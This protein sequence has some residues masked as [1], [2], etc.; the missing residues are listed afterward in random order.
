MT[1][2]QAPVQ[3]GA[4]EEQIQAVVSGSTSDGHHTFDELYDY[5]MLYNA[6]SAN[7]WLEAG[8][9]VVKSWRHSDGEL[10]FGGGWFIVTAT[11]PTGQ[12]S[13]HYRAANW[14]LF[15]VPEVDLPPKYDGHSPADAADRLRRAL[16]VSASADPSDEHHDAEERQAEC[17]CSAYSE[18]RGGGYFELMLEPEPDCPEHGA[19]IAAE[20]EDH[21]ATVTGERDGLAKALCAIEM[22]SKAATLEEV[23]AGIERWTRHRHEADRLIEE[24]YDYGLCL[25]PT[26]GRDIAGETEAEVVKCGPEPEEWDR[27]GAAYLRGLRR[28]AEIVRGGR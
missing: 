21:A 12:V 18:D 11:L 5:R 13:N 27:E 4:T 15:N 7:G 3:G 28:A 19:G 22:R 6:H 9:D 10:C 24:L 14:D 2:Q 8:I 17:K 1:N 16:S 26:L 23:V 25:V 20:S